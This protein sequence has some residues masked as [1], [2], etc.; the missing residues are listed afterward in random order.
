M[1]ALGL[2]ALAAALALGMWMLVRE[3]PGGSGERVSYRTAKLA[4]E[5]II[6]L[7]VVGLLLLGI[8]LAR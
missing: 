6:I 5:A 1:I 8:G 2:T 7:G 3:E 4:I